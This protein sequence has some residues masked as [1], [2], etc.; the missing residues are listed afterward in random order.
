MR[1][2]ILYVIEHPCSVEC[3]IPTMSYICDFNVRYAIEVGLYFP[4]PT[5]FDLLVIIA[6]PLFHANLYYLRSFLIIFVLVTIRSSFVP[7]F[8][9]YLI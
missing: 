4:C 2:N 8:T 9:F 3:V 7:L 5:I 1:N 6:V